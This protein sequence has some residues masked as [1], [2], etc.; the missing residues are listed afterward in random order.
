MG[1]CSVVDE[2]VDSSDLLL[3][4][5]NHALHVGSNRY[6]R[7]KR[8]CL[9]SYSRTF[10]ANGIRGVGSLTVVHGDISTSRSQRDGDGAPIPR[11]PPVTRPTRSLSSFMASCSD[12]SCA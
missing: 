12:S 11:L 4:P 1:D 9:P 7:L 6:I 3:D 5:S 2:D 8:D 10:A